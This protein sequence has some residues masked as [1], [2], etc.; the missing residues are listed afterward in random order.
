NVVLT[1]ALAILAWG[2]LYQAWNA[3]FASFFQELFPTRTRVTGFAVSQNIGLA[4]TAFMPT[5]FAIVAPPG[6][7][8]VPF[9]IGSICFGMTVIGAIAAWSARETHRIHLNDL[10][11]KD[12]IPVPR[13]E[14][15]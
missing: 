14:F 11:A 15:D 1:V 3:S 4:I 7:T 10:G 12:A 13:D 9:K 8:G 5:I 6:S 2:L